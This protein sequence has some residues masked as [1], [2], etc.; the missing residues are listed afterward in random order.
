M[1]VLR[2]YNLL[3]AAHREEEGR[4]DAIWGN[5][6]RLDKVRWLDWKEGQNFNRRGEGK[7]EKK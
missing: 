3:M 7:E 4:V 1:A 5:K 2:E 6:E